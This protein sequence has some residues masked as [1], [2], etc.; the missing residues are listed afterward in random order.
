MKKPTSIDLTIHNKGSN[1]E[2]RKSV[3]SALDFLNGVGKRPARVVEHLTNREGNPQLHTHI[4]VTNLTAAQ[5][6]QFRCEK[7]LA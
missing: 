4:I 3:K 6:V 2:Y 5:M 7:G 1:A